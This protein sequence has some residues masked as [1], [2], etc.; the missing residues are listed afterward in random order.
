MR[1]PRLLSLASLGVSIAAANAAA[2]TAPPPAPPPPACA[3]PEHR[4]FDFWL[5]QWDVSGGPQLDRIVGRNTI[6]RVAAGCGLREH[7]VNAGGTDGHSLNVY[8]RD[9]RHWTQFWIGADG[10]I[11]RL[12][13]GLR[14]DGAMAMEGTLP[15][16]RG[17]IQRQR[18]VW[19]PKPD[20][21]V[22]QQ[23]D[24]S[25]D[26]GATWQVSF[27]GVYRRSAR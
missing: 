13:G 4:Q 11:L 25:E 27:V 18:I 3:T 16:G 2:Q 15:N 17:G 21:S 14:G 8:D 9:A 22:V 23:W 24:T 10:V 5:G 20:G 19:T 26:D 7:W 6:S 12:E 1:L